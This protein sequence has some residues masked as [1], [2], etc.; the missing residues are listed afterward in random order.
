MSR[1]EH[2]CARY[3]AEY[4]NPRTDCFCTEAAF[5]TQEQAERYIER[6]LGS[7]HGT[8]AVVKEY[9]ATE[10]VEPEDQS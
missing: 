5:A 3:F 9:G 8:S 10:L 6:R 7:D 4:F 2:Q 1:G